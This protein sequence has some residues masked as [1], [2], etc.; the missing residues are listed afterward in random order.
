MSNTE[1]CT[2]DDQNKLVNMIRSC[3]DVLIIKY[4]RLVCDFI[5]TFDLKTICYLH[6]TTANV[7]IYPRV[8]FHFFR[9]SLY[10][11]CMFVI[12]L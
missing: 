4:M 12:K 6:L 10:D 7:F 8:S 11:V 2:D 5:N 3:L 9:Y 1:Y